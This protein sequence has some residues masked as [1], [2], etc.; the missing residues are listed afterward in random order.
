MTDYRKKIKRGTEE[1][2]FGPTKNPE[3]ESFVIEANSL[4]ELEETIRNLGNA[5][6]SFISGKDVI[7]GPFEKYEMWEEKTPREGIFAAG[8]A[9]YRITERTYSPV[10]GEVQAIRLE[11]EKLE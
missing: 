10:P 11:I 7:A 3:K 9:F 5:G 4:E 2:P 8:G 1:L 6:F